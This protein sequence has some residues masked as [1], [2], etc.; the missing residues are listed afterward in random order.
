MTKIGLTGGIG[1]GK[2]T[3]A[4]MFELLGVP[5]YYSDSK[6]KLLMTE[7][8]RLRADLINLLGTEVY[9]KSGEI[10]KD[11]LSKLIFKNQGLLSKVNS[12]V[13]P[14]VKNDFEDFCIIHRNAPYIIKESAI[15]IE[16]G[17]YKQL[18]KIIL[19]IASETARVNRVKER[20]LMDRKSITDRISKQWKDFEKIKFS[21]F[22]IENNNQNFIIPK[23]LDIH[24]QLL[25]N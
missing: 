4:K 18:D 17:L 14:I 6:A 2:T 16:T 3:I 22:I 11:Y 20:D 25:N 1:S 13:H 8:K 19:V 24:K 7:H 15:L 9:L 12:I 10:N 21:D 5:I 23:I